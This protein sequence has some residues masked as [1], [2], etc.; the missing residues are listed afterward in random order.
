MQDKLK[1]SREERKKREA[2]TTKLS[3]EKKD[4]QAS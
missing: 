1:E 3:A 2:N 4:V